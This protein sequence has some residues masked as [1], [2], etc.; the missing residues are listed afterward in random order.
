MPTSSAAKRSVTESPGASPAVS[1]ASVRMQPISSVLFY[2]YSRRTRSRSRSRLIGRAVREWERER[3]RKF[4]SNN[5]G[6]SRNSTAS[7]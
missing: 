3:V 5:I 1:T 2:W 7:G 6:T 4:Y